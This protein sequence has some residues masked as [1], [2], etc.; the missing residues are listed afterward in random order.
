[1]MLHMLFG[2]K[3]GDLTY[4]KSTIPIG[5][6]SY[7]VR[8]VIEAD[9]KKTYIILPIPKEPGRRKESCDV[10]VPIKDAELLKH[11]NALPSKQRSQY[12]K[13]ILRKQLD[14][15]YRRQK[16][17]A[18]KEVPVARNVSAASVQPKKPTE[19]STTPK[20][21]DDDYRK[22]LMELSGQK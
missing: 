6:F 15:N 20:G 19:V 4:W 11:L 13:K 8:L 2:K 16:A 10:K 18:G 12:I 1:M 5:M 14:W 17:A 21:A 7:Y 22:M 3:D 9:I